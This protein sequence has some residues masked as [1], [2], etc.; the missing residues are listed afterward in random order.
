M[1]NSHRFFSNTSCRAYPCHD[2]QDLNCL[3]CYCPLYFVK[4]EGNYTILEDGSKDCSDCKLPHIPENYD[5]ILEQISQTID[6]GSFKQQ[7]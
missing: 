3:F 2:L 4:C 7:I 5:Y 6:K 1:E